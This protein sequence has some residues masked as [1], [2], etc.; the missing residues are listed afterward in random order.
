MCALLLLLPLQL[1]P[2]EMQ[3]VLKRME[4]LGDATEV[5]PNSNVLPD[6]GVPADGGNKHYVPDS[7]SAGK[8]GEAIRIHL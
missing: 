8:M 7:G 5:Q 6:T 3:R 4:T 1:S 2:D